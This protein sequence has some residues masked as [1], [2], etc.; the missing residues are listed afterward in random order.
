MPS[1]C[2]VHRK[3]LAL[4]FPDWDVVADLATFSKFLRDGTLVDAIIHVAY[5]LTP[6]C[7]RVY[8]DVQS[9]LTRNPHYP[10]VILSALAACREKLR[11]RQTRSH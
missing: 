5:C 11:R 10:V 8:E 9:F 1:S 6:E 7:Q 2:S 4:R 3:V